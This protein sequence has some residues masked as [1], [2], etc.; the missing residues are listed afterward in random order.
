MFYF[1][2]K[3]KNPVFVSLSDS[4]FLNM[5]ANAIDFPIFNEI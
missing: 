2:I 5:S 3:K 1:P 4:R